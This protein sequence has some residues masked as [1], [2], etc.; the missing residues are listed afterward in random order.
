MNHLHSSDR[1]QPYKSFLVYAKELTHFLYCLTIRCIYFFNSSTSTDNSFSTLVSAASILALYP[2]SSHNTI[3]SSPA[4]H[5]AYIHVIHYHQSYRN[6]IY[7]YHLRNPHFSKY[8][9][10]RICHLLIIIF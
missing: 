9:V 5:K 1:L 2:Q 4:S 3:E 7:R 10:I 8:S 6:L